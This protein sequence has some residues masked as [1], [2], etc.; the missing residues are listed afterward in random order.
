MRL[1]GAMSGLLARRTKRRFGA[2]TSSKEQ[3]ERECIWITY[4]GAIHVQ[5][6]GLLSFSFLSGSTCASL[7]DILIAAPFGAL[8]ARN[9]L[10]DT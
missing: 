8:S 10:H 6:T 4:L 2:C 1:H 9:T 5:L 3:W 7:Y